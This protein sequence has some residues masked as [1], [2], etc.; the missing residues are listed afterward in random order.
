MTTVLHDLRYA[1]RMMFK[2][3]ALSLLAVL[4][5]AL[6][7]GANTTIFSVVDAVLLRPFP[8]PEPQRLVDIKGF[9]PQRPQL[10]TISTHD[11]DD[12]AKTARTVE[13]LAV[14]RDGHFDVKVNGKSQ[15][16]PSGIA[17]ASLFDVLG[18]RPAAGRFFTADE[19]Q[20]GRNHVAVISY[21]FWQKHFGGSASAIGDT[22]R[23]DEEPFTVVGVLPRN[24]ELPSL[25]WMEVWAPNTTDPD[26]RIGRHLRNRQVFARLRPGVTIQQAQ[27]EFETLAAQTARQYPDTN[28]G[29][30]ARVQPLMDREI[31]DTR[32]PLGI[33]FAAVGVVLLIACV[34][35]VNLLLTRVTTRRGEFAVRLA[36]GA[37]TRRLARLLISETLLLCA[38]GGALGILLSSWSL[39][40]LVTII[41]RSTPRLEQ[42]R[43]DGSAVAFGALLA[44]AIGIVVGIIPAWRAGT[45]NVE[46]TLKESGSRRAGSRH[47]VGGML[48]RL[49][50]ALAMVLLIGA[51]L[52]AQSFY[53]LLSIPTDF[54]P[55]G[56]TTAWVIPPPKGYVK[57]PQVLELYRRFGEQLRA[58]PGVRS[59]AQ[60]S[61]GPYFGWEEATEYVPADRPDIGVGKYPEAH[62]ANISPNYFA[63]LGIPLLKGRDFAD[64][65]TTSS[66]PVAIVN[67]AFAR[68]NWP[69]GDVIGK[70]VKLVRTGDFVEVV[71]VVADVRVWPAAMDPKPIIY[72]PYA[73][74]T[75]W[76]TFF[77]LRADGD[78][79]ALTAAIRDRVQNVEPNAS[80]ANVRTLR[81]SMA[82]PLQRP[83][84][85]M[86]LMVLFATLA[87]VL[88]IV[89]VYGVISFATAQRTREIGVRM[90]LGA[91]R[92]EVL[93]MV[94]AGSFRLVV[95]GIVVG[96]VAALFSVRVLQ[97]MLYGIRATDPA[98]F[99][100]VPLLLAAI[101][102]LACFFPARRAT[103][104]DPIEALRTE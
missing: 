13:H 36:L 85:N 48:A 52:L 83:R 104:V 81:E 76:A 43:I 50:V 23:L 8:F 91:G 69:G 47:F 71:G 7:I 17:S 27:A 87:T 79:A 51:A 10:T 31:G 28:A 22:I 40:A 93:R 33:L 54:Q 26:L 65:D 102:M 6:G 72:Y 92:G 16:T 78:S 5:L 4:S 42:V 90:A 67:Q 64:T 55:T 19:D 45:L 35:V 94:L 46:A 101:A 80:V 66:T 41:P 21:A 14:W 18:A 97:S 56:V 34:N 9:N 96:A 70:R 84:F 63:T 100:A 74:Q 58:L 53:R 24:F 30:S 68:A 38:I 103:R 39:D 3:P 89:G 95:T 75:R 99:V 12:W 57:Q 1:S 77:I 73:Q 20:P 62:Y 86:T 60:G 44:L 49:E 11:V 29:W 2:S 88:A 59:V 25:D 98:T 61:A 15:P 82:R 32:R 37:N